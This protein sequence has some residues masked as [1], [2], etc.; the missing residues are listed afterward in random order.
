MEFSAI[1][2]LVGMGIAVATFSVGRL[3]ASNL[4]GKE[5]GA[6]S[7]DIKYI[8][9]SISRIEQRVDAD[10]SRLEGRADEVSHQISGLAQEAARARETAK[11]AHHRLDDH[12]SREQM[13]PDAKGGSQ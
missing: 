9:E 1:A 11:S 3:S 10:I 2:A 12:L 6:L 5:A 4:A 8:K 13:L 7:A